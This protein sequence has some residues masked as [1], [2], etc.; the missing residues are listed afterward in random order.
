MESGNDVADC[1]QLN[2]HYL[3][4]RYGGRQKPSLSE[5]PHLE[6]VFGL[7]V[8]GHRTQT[9]SLCRLILRYQIKILSSTRLYTD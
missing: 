3:T 5:R 4:L 9:C 6:S 2:T 8:L 7:S 1:N